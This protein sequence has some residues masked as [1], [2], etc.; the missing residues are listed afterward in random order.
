MVT[1]FPSELPSSLA[2]SS[3]AVS[4]SG[5]MIFALAGWLL[6]CSISFILAY[7]FLRPQ[8]FFP[9]SGYQEVPTDEEI[10]GQDRSDR[11]TGVDSPHLCRAG[12]RSPILGLPFWT[13]CAVGPP[14]A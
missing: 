4:F 7:L 9:R 8:F 14:M 3:S 2:G 11:L 6:C 10:D 1:G 5:L 12:Q 13:P